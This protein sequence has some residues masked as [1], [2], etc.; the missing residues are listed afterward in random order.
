MKIPAFIDRRKV[1]KKGIFFCFNVLWDYLKWFPHSCTQVLPKKICE[2][3]KKVIIVLEVIST[4][5]SLYSQFPHNIV[6]WNE[7]WAV[8]ES[9]KC[10]VAIWH[11]KKK[12][13]RSTFYKW[14]EF[15]LHLLFYNF[16][17]LYFK[18]LQLGSPCQP[19]MA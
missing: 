4:A 7:I 18:T 5:A 19:E 10:Q 3:N 17:Q 8:P 11:E 16:F 1:A 9:I 12:G 13:I 15:F 2:R 14:F 6:M